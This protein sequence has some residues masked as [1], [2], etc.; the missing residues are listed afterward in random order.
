MASAGPEERTKRRF[1]IWLKTVIGLVIGAVAL[2]FLISRL[3][4]DWHNI[5]WSEIRFSY[6]LLGAAFAV[7]LFV[8]IPLF[9][10]TWK[11][12]LR[13]MDERIRLFDSVA[14]LTVSQMGKYIPG[15][16]WFTLGRAFL[17]K[18]K[19]I[20]EAKT[21]VSA[22]ME[23]G[24]ALLAALLLF[25]LTL[26]LLPRTEV[27]GYVYYAFALIPLCLVVIY[28][29]VLN[30]LTNFFLKKL[31]QP[32]IDVRFSFGR[33]LT[34][35]GLYLAM[36]LAQG[37]GCFLLISSFY[38][39]AISKLPIVIG[40]YALAWILGFLSFVTPAGLGVREGILT[41]ALRFA[42]PEP[43]AII[44]ALLARVWITITEALVAVVMVFFIRRKK[45]EAR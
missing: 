2:Y 26:I 5:P 30:R 32:L 37:I 35:I 24:F 25:A 39:L 11:V 16:V 42:M 21:V 29:P 12:L 23:A 22:F 33:I 1:P 8:Y 9:G 43:V 19:G 28:P 41:F 7:L 44:A 27:P 15:K 4:R 3:A 36:W 6:P 13:A 31:H 45:Q 10:L 18:R 17:A 40:G 14:I 20:P 34:I 38:P